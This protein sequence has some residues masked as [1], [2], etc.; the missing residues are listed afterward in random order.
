MSFSHRPHFL[1]LDEPTNHL[2]VETI[3][4]LGKAL[5]DYKVILLLLACFYLCL[6]SSSNK[7]H[8]YRYSLRPTMVL[9]QGGVVMVTHDERLVR[10]VC[11]EVWLCSNGSVTRQDGGFEQYRKL[12]EDQLRDL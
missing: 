7:T 10:S 2:D 3:E 11:K 9:L 4:A 1:I 12:L 5:N 8:V 6:L